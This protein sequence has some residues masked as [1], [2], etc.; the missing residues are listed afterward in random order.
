MQ[1][2]ASL[3]FKAQNTVFSLTLAVIDFVIIAFIFFVYE[4]PEQIIYS[5]DYIV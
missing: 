4:T 5:C 1:N 3:N 2:Y